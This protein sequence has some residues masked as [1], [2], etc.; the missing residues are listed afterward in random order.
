MAGMALL[1]THPDYMRFDGRGDLQEFPATLYKDF[2][3]YVAARYAGQFWHALPRDVAAWSV[4]HHGSESQLA[5]GS[6]VR[7]RLCQ[8]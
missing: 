2:L 8:V 6:A 1:D 5:F 7:S 3:Q 4:Q